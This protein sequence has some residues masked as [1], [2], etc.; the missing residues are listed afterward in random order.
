[1]GQSTKAWA[2]GRLKQG[3]VWTHAIYSSSG[4]YHT[5][6]QARKDETGLPPPGAPCAHFTSCLLVAILAVGLLCEFG[7]S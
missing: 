1:M 6:I 2:E 5:L 4:W 3:G 7:I